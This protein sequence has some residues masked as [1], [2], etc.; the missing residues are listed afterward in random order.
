M[1]TIGAQCTFTLPS[2]PVVEICFCIRTHGDKGFAVR[3][4]RNIVD[5]LTVTPGS[6]VEPKGR[7][8][9]ENQLIV[10]RDSCRTEWA[11]RGNR[12]C[13]HDCRMSTDLLSTLDQQIRVGR[14]TSP[15]VF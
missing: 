4:K 1:S 6:R 5:K 10:I 2:L 9:V 8:V 3:G 7:P 13:I 14:R 12:H 15:T 11:T